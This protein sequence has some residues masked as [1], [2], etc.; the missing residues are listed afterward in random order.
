MELVVV[1]DATIGS[2]FAIGASGPLVFNSEVEVRQVVA[3][4]GRNTIDGVEVGEILATLHVD[5]VLG[6]SRSTK[7]VEILASTKILHVAEEK[8]GTV[9]LAVGEVEVADGCLDGGIF[10]TAVF[11]DV[12]H[13][14]AIEMIDM[15]CVLGENGAELGGET[16]FSVLEIEGRREGGETFVDGVA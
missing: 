5:V 13:A 11:K 8:V 6:D 14:V 4:A 10:P 3:D 12:G 15:A 16:A 1:E 7:V 2:L 9:F